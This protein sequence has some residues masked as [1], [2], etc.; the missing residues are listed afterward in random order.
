MSRNFRKSSHLSDAK[1]SFCVYYHFLY[2]WRQGFLW[3]FAES[4]YWYDLGH[5]SYRRVYEWRE[6]LANYLLASTQG[7]SFACVPRQ[8]CWFVSWPYLIWL[9]DHRVR[10]NGR[11]VRHR[12]SSHVGLLWALFAS[13]YW[14]YRCAE[15]SYPQTAYF[16]RGLP[17]VHCHA[18]RKDIGSQW[19]P[20]YTPYSPQVLAV[21]SPSEQNWMIIDDT[22]QFSHSVLRLHSSRQSCCC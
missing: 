14:S 11:Q 13:R 7:A 10:A 3:Q 19:H 8:S 4:S 18:D 22:C 9:S 5:E 2:W 15:L 21:E 6:S 20:D 16:L 1:Q 12:H 17:D